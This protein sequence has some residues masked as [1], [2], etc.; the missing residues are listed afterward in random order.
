[1]KF[2]IK[3]QLPPEPLTRGPPHPDPRSLCPEL[4][5]LNPPEKKNPV[6]STVAIEESH[7]ME[8]TEKNDARTQNASSQAASP[9]ARGCFFH[10]AA[11]G[12]NG[13]DVHLKECH[14]RCVYENYSRS[15]IKE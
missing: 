8:N 1:M 9:V 15:M 12:V 11:K 4:N 3:L 6:Y 13:I 14:P 2:L 10:N 7:K 5:L